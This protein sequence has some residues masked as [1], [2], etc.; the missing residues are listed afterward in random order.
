MPLSNDWKIVEVLLFL[1]TQSSCIA[2]RV[3]QQNVQT[4][5]GFESKVVCSLSALWTNFGVFLTVYEREN[6]PTQRQY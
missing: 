5:A 2:K 6:S 3:L 4:R 1:E